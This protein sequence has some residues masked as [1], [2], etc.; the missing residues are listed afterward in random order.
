MSTRVIGVA[1]T[2]AMALTVSAL[3]RS[4]STGSPPAEALSGGATTVF[5]DTRNAFSLPARNL[6]EDHR[7][8]FFVGNSFFNQNWV[9]A[10][11]STAGRDG[12]G[13]L[14]NARSC[15]AC[16]FK[17]GRSRPPEPGEPMSTMLLRISVPGAGEHGAPKPDPVYGDQIQGQSIPGVPREADVFVDYTERAGAFAD[18]EAYSLRRPTYR[19]TG[20]GFGALA[21]Q[22]LVSPRISPG[23][24]GLGLL[25]A[26]P[27]A[28]LLRLADPGDADSDGISGRPNVVWN[29]RTRLVAIGR[30][31]WKAEQPSVA[32]QTAA[33]FVGDIGITSP[34][35]PHE[36]HSAQE[37]IPVR[38]QSPRAFEVSEKIFRAV[39]LYARS[40]AVPAARTNS[41][42]A[43]QGRGIFSSLRCD[44]CHVAALETGPSPELPEFANQRIRPYTDLLLHDMGDALA[45]ERPAF[46][47][48]GREWRTPP[49][50]GLGLIRKVNGHTFLLHDGRARNA[51]EAILWHGGEA[52][53]ARE[54]FRHLSKS[55]RVALL[56]FLD[57]L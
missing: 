30:F 15:S 36:N 53:A 42:G 17:D 46:V 33:A 57:S 19:I 6:R 27:E 44:S 29:V 35:F 43:S 51:T 37:P 48:T 41:P 32:Q 54:R 13:P 38:S 21:R 23:I 52:A 8:S 18:G 7:P 3:T 24:I 1:A 34:L 9:I 39:S 55:D 49:L 5:D 16:H 12:L 31:G 10:P 20:L 26:V 47:A 22:L 25:E 50:W 56:A 40:L 14:F 2:V 28:T 4:A 45:D 11:A